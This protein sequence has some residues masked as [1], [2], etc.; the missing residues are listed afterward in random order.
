MPGARTAENVSWGLNEETTLAAM[1]NQINKYSQD[2]R[3]FFLTYVPAAPHYPYDSIP[4]RFR[5]FKKVGMNDYTPVYLNEL[6]YMDWV[7][8]SLVDQLKDSGLLEHTLVIITNDH[9]EMLGSEGDAI[10]HGWA[11]TPELANT[12]LIIMDPRKP[13]WH[14]N[15]AIGSQVDFLPSVLDCLNVP[16]PPG[17]LYEGRSLYRPDP[18]H[19]R[20]IYLNTCQ[21]FGVLEGNRISVGD[22]DGEGKRGEGSKK[23]SFTISNQD[24]KT[25]FT[26]SPSTGHPV[27]IHE[28]DEFQENLLRNYSLYCQSICTVKNSVARK[29]GESIPGLVRASRQ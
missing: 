4:E 20:R 19:D 29:S 6:L 25:I 3:R 7:L 11:F 24:T 8:A 5:K 18:Q 28:F 23:P 22:R 15:Y 21:Q 12:P 13:G 26:E 9:G 27:A 10:G 2:K 1:R 14:V 17:Q 16:V